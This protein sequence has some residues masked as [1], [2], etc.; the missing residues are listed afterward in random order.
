MF[1]KLNIKAEVCTSAPVAPKRITKITRRERLFGQF[2]KC[3]IKL[4]SEEI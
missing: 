2:V 4:K 1:C 3:W